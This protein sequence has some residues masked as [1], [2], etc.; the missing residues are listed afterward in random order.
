MQGIYNALRFPQLTT[1]RLRS[2]IEDLGQSCENYDHDEPWRQTRHIFARWSSNPSLFNT[3]QSILAELDK[4]RAVKGW[5]ASME[6]EIRDVI[7]EVF[8]DGGKGFHEFSLYGG[9]MEE[10]DVRSIQTV[11]QGASLVPSLPVIPPLSAEVAFRASFINTTAQPVLLHK[12]LR[13]V[14][15]GQSVARLDVPTGTI[16]DPTAVAFTLLLAN[17]CG[18]PFFDTLRTREQLG[19][20]V[21]SNS[22]A[23]RTQNY[24]YFVVQTEKL[25]GT[26]LLERIDTWIQDWIVTGLG[27]KDEYVEIDGE[28]DTTVLLVEHFNK[29]KDVVLKELQ[30]KHPSMETKTEE[31]ETLLLWHRENLAI[32]EQTLAALRNMTRENF[33]ATIKT[34]FGNKA[35]WRA[36]VLDGSE[37]VDIVTDASLDGW[38][39]T[40]EDSLDAEDGVKI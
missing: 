11:R 21:G 24:I 39:V 6:D 20:V 7:H 12:Y 18:G 29:T 38:S 3:P 36:V 31:Q 27:E 14:P 2:A 33:R 22:R 13:R 34:Y 30:S 16:S 28:K 32:R 9:N 8:L 25:N 17:L 15:R 4:I 10:Q 1:S 40:T 26:E 35:D 5:E 19:Y 37:G 23:V